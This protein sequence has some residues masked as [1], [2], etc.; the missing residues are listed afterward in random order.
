VDGIKN[1]ADIMN[2]LFGVV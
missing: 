1:V 2:L